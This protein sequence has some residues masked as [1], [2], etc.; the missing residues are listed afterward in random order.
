[1]DLHPF[2]TAS[3]PWTVQHI[4]YD[5]LQE[6]YPHRPVPLLGQPPQPF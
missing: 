1:M 6:T 2:W 3:L 5:G 4:N